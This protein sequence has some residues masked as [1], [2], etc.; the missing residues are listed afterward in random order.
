VVA[1]KVDKSDRALVNVQAVLRSRFAALTWHDGYQ[2][3]ELPA[4][5]EG[6]DLGVVPVQWEDNLPQVAI[7]MVA[8]GVP[9]LTSDR[10]G[11]QELGGANPDFTF[12]AGDP[13][14]FS[15]R[16]VAV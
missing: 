8:H 10:G 11:A 7:E 1:S 16:L 6:V 4:I 15:A 9:I 12:R 13:T 3:T 5:L 2:P 14:D